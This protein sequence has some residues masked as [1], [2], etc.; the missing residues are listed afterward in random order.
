[1]GSQNTDLEKPHNVSSRISQCDLEASAVLDV[2]QVQNCI[3]DVAG[4][5]ANE[6]QLGRVLRHMYT[7]ARHIYTGV[8]QA[9]ASLCDTPD[10][11]GLQDVV[12]AARPLETRCG[13]DV[14][15]LR[16]VQFHGSHY[17][18]Q[19]PPGQGA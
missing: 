18:F 10:T 4:R 7:G 15:K 19:A 13:V 5:G 1:M 17:D 16:A 14:R 8:R 12:A 3:Y 6:D 9:M 11:P 2:F